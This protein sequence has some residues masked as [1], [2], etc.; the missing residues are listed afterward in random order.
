[1]GELLFDTV[2]VEIVDAAELVEPWQDSDRFKSYGGLLLAADADFEFKPGDFTPKSAR[3]FDRG[4]CVGVCSKAVVA[5]A[6]VAG[7]PI[8]LSTTTLK[9]IYVLGL[10]PTPS[11]YYAWGN[12]F[13]SLADLKEAVGSPAGWERGKF[14]DWTINTFRAEAAKIEIAVGGKPSTKD[15]RAAAESGDFPG[16]EVIERMIGGVNALNE[17]LGYPDVNS[18]EKYDYLEFGKYVWEING[19]DKFIVDTFDILASRDRGPTF[20]SIYKMFGSIGNFREAVRQRVD[21]RARRLELYRS[22]INDIH[23]GW[24]GN[25]S[26]DELLQRCTRLELTNAVAPKLHWREVFRLVDSRVAA[27]TYSGLSAVASDQYP[28]L[29]TEM[30]IKESKRLGLHGYIWPEPPRYVNNTN[31]MNNIFVANDEL[32]ERR[33]VRA[34]KQ[35]EYR[36][37]KLEKESA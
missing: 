35:Q 11:A 30:I 15:Y 14:N 8:P 23:P 27:T 13:T 34:K 12:R 20:R 26:D 37:Q 16:L 6:Q 18:M 4:K 7:E 24:Y 21:D 22:Q 36:S 3:E 2:A 33:A 32:A 29:S 9:R 5:M 19:E 31:F 17:L 1:M 28:N 25:L 10:G